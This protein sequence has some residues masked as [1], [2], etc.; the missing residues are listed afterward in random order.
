MLLERVSIYGRGGDGGRG[1]RAFQCRG[2]FFKE[3]ATGGDGGKGGNVILAADPTLD[4]FSHLNED[5]KHR[6]GKGK[7]GSRKGGAGGNGTDVIVNVP[8]GTAVIDK[9]TNEL[10][11]DIE[12]VGHRHLLALGG[13]GG[14]GNAHFVTPADRVPKTVQPPTAG[15]ERTVELQLKPFCHVGLVGYEQASIHSVFNN[16]VYETQSPGVLIVGQG[17]ATIGWYYF[18]DGKFV[19]FMNYVS[20]GMVRGE[21]SLPVDYCRHLNRTRV[22]T[23]VLDPGKE[24]ERNPAGE[25]EALQAALAE[26][27][28]EMI[29][30]PSII[31]L[32]MAGSDPRG[33]KLVGELQSVTELPIFMLDI[34]TG[35]GRDEILETCRKL[36]PTRRYVDFTSN[37]LSH[38]FDDG[39]MRTEYLGRRPRESKRTVKI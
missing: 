25:F 22:L 12:R 10:A 20:K 7:D 24:D 33:T 34:L 32:S 16:L 1:K 26:H 3:L 18:R 6:A 37:G 35:N 19:S 38:G 36:Q 31:I 23:Y 14:L 28:Q 9:Q 21:R 39:S 2:G 5:R 17:K 13:A 30:K 11:A 8:I 29:E 15:E 4:D 27:D